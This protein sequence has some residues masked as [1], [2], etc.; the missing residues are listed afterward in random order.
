MTELIHEVETIYTDA[1]ESGDRSHAMKRLRVP[2]LGEKQS[3]IVTFRVGIFIGKLF[4]IS[5]TGSY[6]TFLLH[7]STLIYNR[8]SQIQSIG[9]I[10]V[11]LP[12]LITFIAIL[13]KNQSGNPLAWR[14]ALHLYRSPFL[15]IFLTILVSIDVYGWSASGVNHILIFRIDPRH[16]LTYQQLLEMGTCLSVFWFLSFIAFVVTSYFDF[17]AFLQLLIFFILTVLFLINPAPIFHC[18][19]RYWLLKTLG[20]ISTGAFHPILFGEFWVCNQLASLELDFFDLENF[21]CFYISDRQWWSTNLTAPATP[22][23]A[24]CTGWSR[25]LLQAFLVSLPSTLQFI[26]CVR[27]YYD[28]K[29]KFPHLANAGKYGTSIL[30]AIANTVR[31]ATNLNDPEHPKKNPFVYTWITTAFISSTYKL[32]WDLKMSWGLFDKNADKNRFLRDHLVYSSKYYYYFAIV[33]DIILRYIWVINIFTQ[34]TT[35]TAEYSDMTGFA[36]ALVELIRRF[37][38]NFFRLENEHLNNCGQFRAVRDISIA[39]IT[40]GLDFRLIDAKLSQ[41]P[42]IRNRRSKVQCPTIVEE[43]IIETIE[44]ATMND[45]ENKTANYIDNSVS[46]CDDVTPILEMNEINPTLRNTA[47]R[48]CHTLLSSDDD[49]NSSYPVLNVD[50]L[51][52]FLKPLKSV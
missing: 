19:A 22:K 20:R 5:V 50:H 48:R 17:Y 6:V 37:I 8:I 1:F 3:A 38:W 30:L 28:S 27:R 35:G 36:F 13:K 40:T 42:G 11:L 25:F 44:D 16:H 41:E 47:S 9:M 23:G 39:P 43:E 2:P 15:V 7:T 24:F 45:S 26:Q 32:L 33:Q 34:F 52:R 18:S 31:R 29:L 21:F 14:E 46:T 49:S 51:D 12:I 4:H 10:C